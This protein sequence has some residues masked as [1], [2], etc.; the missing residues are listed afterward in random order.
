MMATSARLWDDVLGLGNPFHRRR[1]ASGGVSSSS[2][3]SSSYDEDE[4]TTLTTIYG[5]PRQE[6]EEEEEEEVQQQ[7]DVS[8]Q[9][10]HVAN[11]RSTVYG[12]DVGTPNDDDVALK[13]VITIT[14]WRRRGGASS[15]DHKKR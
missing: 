10:R 7:D 9:A 3:T 13:K 15:G 6:E 5:I 14:I 8:N 11:L 12:V 2:S 4:D 1:R